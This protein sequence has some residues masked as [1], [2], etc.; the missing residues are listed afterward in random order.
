LQGH[1]RNTWTYKPSP[2]VT[3]Q[4]PSPAPKSSNN[5]ERRTRSLLRVFSLQRRFKSGISKGTGIDQTGNG[6]RGEGGA[7]WTDV[8]W[9]KDLLAAD[10]P[11][12]RIITFGYNTNVTKGYKP[13]NQGNIFSHA[14]DLLYGLEAKRRKAPDRDLVFIAHSLGGIVVKEV[15]RRS[16]AD[17]DSK[18]NRIFMSTSGVL[19]FGTPHRG[20]KD[21]ASF[22][23]GLAGVVGW[24]LGVDT[25][26]QVVHALLPTGP[27]L[28]LCRESFMTQ[29][30]KRGNSL[31]VRTFQETK[32]VVG[33]RW[34]G[35]NRLVLQR[36]AI[37]FSSTD[38]DLD[39]AS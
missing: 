35:F 29:W 33:V 20:S 31:V 34:G 26:D 1:P 23:E 39:C 30:V 17:P 37:E 28:E 12:A 13:V 15:L 36:H 11:T 10:F 4:T 16:E 9:P 38:K 6:G 3:P 18:I 25:N 7:E 14:R 5:D 19:F 21:W 2:R 27:E 8:Y 22:G 32:G 24:L